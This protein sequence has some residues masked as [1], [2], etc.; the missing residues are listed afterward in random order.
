MGGGGGVLRPPLLG[1]LVFVGGVAA[2]LALAGVLVFGTWRIWQATDHAAHVQFQA[3]ADSLRRR[4][5][6]CFRRSCVFTTPRDTVRS[7]LR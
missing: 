7:P 4:L 3:Q 6:E 1:W 5:D 2:G